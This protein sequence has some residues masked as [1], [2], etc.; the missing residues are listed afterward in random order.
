M[1]TYALDRLKDLEAGFPEPTRRITIPFDVLLLSL[2]NGKVVA[3][4]STFSGKASAQVTLNAAGEPMI[5]EADVVK[6]PEEPDDDALL[7]FILKPLKRPTATFRSLDGNYLVQT[8]LAA[9]TQVAL[10]RRDGSKLPGEID[11][12]E[13]FR[14]PL[15]VTVRSDTIEV[16][17]ATTT[18]AFALVK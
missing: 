2:Q 14:S 8:Q 10:F 9:V 6:G 16:H 15:A 12:P 13:P 18:W 4:G 17:T 11:I 5:T 7:R 1:T 3:S